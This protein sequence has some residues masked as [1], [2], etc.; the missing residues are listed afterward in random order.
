MKLLL[1]IGRQRLAE[2]DVGFC[3]QD[4]DRLKLG[5]GLGGSGRL[6]VGPAGKIRGDAAGTE[7]DGQDDDAGDVHT[8]STYAILLDG[9]SLGMTKR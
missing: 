7:S 2:I 3:H 5:D 1:V 4:V 9:S 8:R 6:A